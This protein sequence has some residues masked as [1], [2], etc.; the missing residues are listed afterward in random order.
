MFASYAAKSALLTILF[1]ACVFTDAMAQ[2]PHLVSEIE[3]AESSEVVQ[4]LRELAWDNYEANRVSEIRFDIA[5][6][7]VRNRRLEWFNAV[8]FNYTYYPQFVSDQEFR[9]QFGRFGIGLSVNL[10]T[11][12]QT[13]GRVRIARFERSIAREEIEIQR[14]MIQNEVVQR[15]A[16]FLQS[17]ERLQLQAE[18]VENSKSTVDM[19][20]D[21]FSRGEIDVE[22]LQ[23]AEEFLVSDRERLIMARTDYF[24]ARYDVE[25]II[26]VPLQT[27]FE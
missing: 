21:R 7:E 27:L 6:Q 14:K 4:K 12:V 1:T 16:F 18:A 17:A 26:G 11:L 5:D 20:R 9:D 25:E 19:V 2:V 13:P 24:K 3:A 23:R 22:Q 10:G 15:Y 8:N